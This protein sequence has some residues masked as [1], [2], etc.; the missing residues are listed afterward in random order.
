[1][2]SPKTKGNTRVTQMENCRD[3][4]F[5]WM[6]DEESGSPLSCVGHVALAQKLSWNHPRITYD[7][8]YETLRPVV[9][10]VLTSHEWFIFAW[11]VAATWETL[12][13]GYPLA[14]QDF[15]HGSADKCIFQILS[16]KPGEN[17]FKQRGAEYEIFAITGWAATKVFDQFWTDAACRAI[18]SRVGFTGAKGKRP[19]RHTTELAGLGFAAEIVKGK[20]PYKYATQR[21]WEHA[22]TT[23]WNIKNIL[24]LRFRSHGH[25]CPNGFAHACYKC[26]IGYEDCAAGTHP[27]TYEI[28]NCSK[29]NDD[30]AIFDPY[31]KSATCV[32]CN[33]RF[34][35]QT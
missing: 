22:P 28:G 33:R 23:L 26:A 11:R 9:G 34:K 2:T 14:D 24:D 32:R 13:A 20:G 12:R 29:C 31:V 17:D 30:D 3:K 35:T 27:K 6:F 5:V 8:W 4:L 7:T 1:M 15:V 16:A 10:K 18:A 19:F 25:V 21:C